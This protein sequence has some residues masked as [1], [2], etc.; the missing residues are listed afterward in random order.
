M[1]VDRRGIL[2]FK[3]HLKRMRKGLRFFHFKMPYSSTEWR[4]H[5]NKLL[6]LNDLKEARV[7]WMVWRE[8]GISQ[9][10]VI[11]QPLA[12]EKKQKRGWR[13]VIQKVKGL[14]RESPDVKS[15]DYSLFRKVLLKAREKGFDEA[16]LVNESGYL[17]E[18]TRSN[19]F[20]VKDNIL[21]TPS[22]SCGCLRGITREHVLRLAKKLG[23]G[24]RA[25]KATPAMLLS[26]D[27]AF[28]T[29]S[30]VGIMPLVRIGQKSKYDFLFAHTVTSLYNKNL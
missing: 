24:C 20:F 11:C 18:G 19:L 13:V 14:K 7:R 6:S 4:N 3:D 25:V 2:D 22:L 8:Q 23:M 5:V 1:R 9:S 21:Y 28:V 17:V 12:S 29:N 30:L 27:E 16:I 26:A 10:A 15:L